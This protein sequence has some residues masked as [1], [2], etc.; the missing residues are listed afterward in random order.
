MSLT[1]IHFVRV[2]EELGGYLNW[3]LYLQAFNFLMIILA[4]KIDLLL[5]T[6][7]ARG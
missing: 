3:I 6:F 4:V 1:E 7:V 2:L 5:L